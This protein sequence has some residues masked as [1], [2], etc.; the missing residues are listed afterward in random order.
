MVKSHYE[1]CKKSIMKYKEQNRD[2]I[3]EYARKKQRERYEYIKA[4]RE[5]R[6]I[7]I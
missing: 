2:K 5:L 1:I 7:C 6:Q 3:L 4:C